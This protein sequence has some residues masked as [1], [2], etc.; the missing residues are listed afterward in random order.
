M[1]DVGD[2]IRECLAHGELKR[3]RALLGL[4]GG[5]LKNGAELRFLDRVW[6]RETAAAKP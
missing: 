5:R 2:A 4:A 3:A 6:Q 1:N